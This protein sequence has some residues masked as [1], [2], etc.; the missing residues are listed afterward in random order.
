[1]S[2]PHPTTAKK[3]AEARSG[4][5]LRELA[6]RLGYAASYAATLSKIMRDQSVGLETEN[7]LRRRLGLAVFVEQAA[8]RKPIPPAWV[9]QAADWLAAKE[10]TR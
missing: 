5:S 3:L 8:R 10:K 2:N 6:E 4:D 9:T 7:E 1:M